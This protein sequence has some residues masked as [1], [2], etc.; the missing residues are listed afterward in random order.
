MFVFD[1]LCQENNFVF[2]PQILLIFNS[3]E[4]NS[5]SSL[6]VF[7]HHSCGRGPAETLTG[8]K[9]DGFKKGFGL[10]KND[11]DNEAEQD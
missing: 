2:A 11:V 5:A 1:F 3:L 10:N 9:Q 7:V 8:E 4:L 6:E